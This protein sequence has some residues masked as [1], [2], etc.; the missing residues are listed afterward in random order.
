MAGSFVELTEDVAGSPSF[1]FPVLFE[2]ETADPSHRRFRV[3]ERPY[4]AGV[5]TDAVRAHVIVQGI[6]HDL[7]SLAS[8]KGV[9]STNAANGADRRQFAVMEVGYLRQHG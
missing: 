5:D 7:K 6:S 3:P 1:I 2:P 8:V 4:E 9:K